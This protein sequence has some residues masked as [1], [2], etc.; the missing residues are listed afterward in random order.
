MRLFPEFPLL[1]REFIAVLRTRRAIWLM[2]LIVATSTLIPLISWPDEYLTFGSAYRAREVFAA[3]S[4]VQLSMTLLIV[5]VFTAGA[6]AGERE[7]GTYEMLHSTLLPPSSIVFSKLLASIGYLILVLIATSPC[8]SVLFLLGGIGFE[9]IA[10]VYGLTAVALVSSGIVGLAISMR[11]RRT[12]HAILRSIA[13]VAF[14]NI[15]LL[16]GFMLLVMILSEVVSVSPNSLLRSFELVL[17]CSPFFAMMSLLM[18]GGPGSFSV[19]ELIVGYLVYAGV[20]SAAHLGYMLWR[21]RTPEIA[22]RRKE[23][24]TVLLTRVLAR[25]ARPPDRLTAFTRWVLQL[26]RL[27][28]PIFSNPVFIKEVQSEFS[29]KPRFRRIVFWASLAL[30]FLLSLVDNGVR[31]SIGVPFMFGLGILV[32]VIPGV[33]ASS[34]TREFEQGSIDLLRGTLL[35][36]RSILAGKAFAGAFAWVGIAAALLIVVFVRPMFADPASD[37]WGRGNWHPPHGWILTVGDALVV[38]VGGLTCAFAIAL[39]AL[40]GVIFRRSVT[41]MTCSYLALGGL[42]ILLPVLMAVTFDVDYDLPDEMLAVALN[43][44]A[45]FGVCFMDN[46]WNWTG[47]TVLLFSVLYGG[48]TVG[49]WLLA[50]SVATTSAERDV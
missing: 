5:P 43:P 1:R 14:W 34:V 8:V 28:A 32:L 9:Q 16:F 26:G 20:L 27:G 7:R 10:T 38:V 3:F 44:F 11:S 30:F 41:A 13:W 19:F 50:V 47:S 29:G 37:Y 15:G 17:C 6:I 12:V 40:M 48:A 33:V 25:I 31:V 23:R 49:L 35:P 21:V 45:V 42:F 2:A 46:D 24:R 22:V 36:M 4:V 18:G 39:S